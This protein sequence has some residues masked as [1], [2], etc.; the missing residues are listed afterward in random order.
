MSLLLN[1][2]SATSEAPGATPWIR[3]LHAV[4]GVCAP[5]PATL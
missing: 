5:N 3:M 2:F 1:T 4:P